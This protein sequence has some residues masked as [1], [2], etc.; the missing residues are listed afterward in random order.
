MYQD[1]ILFCAYLEP[2]GPYKFWLENGLSSNGMEDI[3]IRK[4][5]RPSEKL[6]ALCHH[7]VKGPGTHHQKSVNG[8]EVE[9]GSYICGIRAKWYIS[10]D[11]AFA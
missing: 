9:L 5:K 4:M 6:K 7:L 2:P 11:L 10:E 8:V 3:K 1:L